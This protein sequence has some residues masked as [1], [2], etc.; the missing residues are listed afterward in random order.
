VIGV[1]SPAG[2]RRGGR[3]H[4]PDPAPFP[5]DD[6]TPSPPADDQH[7]RQWRAPMGRGRVWW[8]RNWGSATAIGPQTMG[9]RITASPHRTSL[10]NRSTLWAGWARD[11]AHLSKS[12]RA[13]RR[14][15]AIADR[16]PGMG[17]HRPAIG[18]GRTIGR[19]CGWSA[20][21]MSAL[22]RL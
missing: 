12:R 20:H 16:T 1:G 21:L 10:D 5:A 18:R 17:D 6:G 22:T 2:A 15:E 14:R 9:W 8:E 4:R 13:A 3:N 19:H 11:T 7:R